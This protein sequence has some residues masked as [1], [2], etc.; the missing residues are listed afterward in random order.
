LLPN[1]SLERDRK[2]LIDLVDGL[3]LGTVVLVNVTDDDFVD[4]D[5]RSFFL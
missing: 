2:V 3:S 5:A 4:H 1:A